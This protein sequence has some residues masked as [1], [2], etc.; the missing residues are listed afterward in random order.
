MVRPDGTSI[1][2]SLAAAQRPGHTLKSNAQTSKQTAL[3][4]IRLP[5]LIHLITPSK[6]FKKAAHRRRTYFASNVDLLSTGF[7]LNAPFAV[8][9]KNGKHP[10]FGTKKTPQT[11]VCGV[12]QFLSF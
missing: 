7:F 11:K 12:C 4:L 10:P 8:I 1:L 2:V 9:E 3:L 6:I 5:L